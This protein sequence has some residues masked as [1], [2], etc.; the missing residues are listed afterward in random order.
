MVSRRWGHLVLDES[1]SGQLWAEGA[2]FF[3]WQMNGVWH[4]SYGSIRGTELEER[5]L[6]EGGRR[7]QGK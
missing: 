7:K 3:R 6:V 5:M 1:R 2:A 4:V